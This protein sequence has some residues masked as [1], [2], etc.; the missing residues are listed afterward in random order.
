MHARSALAARHR[1]RHQR[2]LLRR[3]VVHFALLCSSTTRPP[4]A[5]PSGGTSSTGAASSSSGAARRA[6]HERARPRT[7]SP[8][9]QRAPP[10]CAAPHALTPPTWPLA[11]VV[12]L[13][14]TPVREVL[15]G[16]RRRTTTACVSALPQHAPGDLHP[17]ARS[18]DGSSYIRTINAGRRPDHD[19]LRR[20][21]L[22]R[23][24]V[25]PER[26]RSDPSARAATGASGAVSAATPR[27]A[28]AR[29]PPSSHRRICMR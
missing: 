7:T 29:D 22:T 24:R 13:P 9:A 17:G 19:R 5:D 26:Q 10:S 4:A 11:G 18:C 27:Q 20:R 8:S 2:R 23:A 25:A 16:H 15:V 6:P 28:R 14:S 12:P 3:L 1:R 21:C